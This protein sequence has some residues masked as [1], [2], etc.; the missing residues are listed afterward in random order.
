MA[1]TIAAF[2]AAMPDPDDALIAAALERRE[3]FGELYDRYMPRVYRYLV[4]RT[5]SPEEAADLTQAVFM[6]ALDALP[7]YRTGQAPFAAWIFRIARNAATDAHRRRRPRSSIPT[8]VGLKL[9]RCEANSSVDCGCSSRRST[10]VSAS[11]WRCAS[12]AGSRPAR[13]RRWS[14]NERKR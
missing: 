4:T 3:L 8:D 13:S 11:C 2:D 12:P 1:L 10:L 14:E 9:Q 6:K 5:A 7:K